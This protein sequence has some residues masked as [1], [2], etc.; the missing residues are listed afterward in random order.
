MSVERRYSDFD[1]LKDYLNKSFPEFLIPPIP[2]KTSKNKNAD[3][4]EY[5]MALL[6]QFCKR[7]LDLA[8]IRYDAYVDSFFTE[9]DFNTKYK[10]T[11]VV[12]P[13]YIS[14]IDG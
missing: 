4:I 2:K 3:T 10:V 8:E 9:R 11:R 12:D 5:R 14:K 1:S 7:L 13:R 6:D